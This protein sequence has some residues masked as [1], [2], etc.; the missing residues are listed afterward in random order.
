MKSHAP[1]F[2]KEGIA[3]SQ[4]TL[5]SPVKKRLG[6]KPAKLVGTRREV[7]LRYRCTDAEET[8]LSPVL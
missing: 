1:N 5:R 6:V 2:T 7:Q 3:A 8:F 4:L